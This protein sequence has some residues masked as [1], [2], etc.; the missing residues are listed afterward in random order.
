MLLSTIV[1][2]GN[3]VK[4]TEE[5][6]RKW[7]EKIVMQTSDTAPRRGMEASG[8]NYRGYNLPKL[9]SLENKQ[10]YNNRVGW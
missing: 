4:E 6:L 2:G 1:I 7:R 8:P 3:I 9:R 5:F 10:R